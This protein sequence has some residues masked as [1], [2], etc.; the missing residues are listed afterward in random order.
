MWTP[1]TQEKTDGFPYSRSNHKQF[2]NDSMPHGHQ[3][4][5]SQWQLFLKART[6]SY[7]QHNIMSP[8]AGANWQRLKQKQ[9]PAVSNDTISWVIMQGATN[10]VS[11]STNSVQQFLHGITSEFML[12][13]CDRRQRSP[14]VSHI[15]WRLT[16]HKA[17][18]V[19]QHL[20]N[21][22]FKWNSHQALELSGTAGTNLAGYL[23]PNPSIPSKQ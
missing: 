10:D 13:P 6:I 2:S 3:Q 21:S 17:H 4:E 23:T 18:M 8:H 7:E 1:E 11:I 9:H 20:Q 14:R 19:N 22:N 16:K 12:P 5:S 15:D